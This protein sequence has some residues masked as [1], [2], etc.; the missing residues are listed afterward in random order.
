M[1]RSCIECGNSFER[2][3]P[4][5]ICCSSKCSNA[6]H[7]RQALERYRR[8]RDQGLSRYEAKRV[9]LTRNDSRQREFACVHCG[10]TAFVLK[11]SAKYCS[12][13]CLGAALAN[14]SPLGNPRVRTDPQKCT[15][16]C[17]IKP[18]SEFSVTKHTML[19]MLRCLEC[20]AKKHSDSGRRH[21][22]RTYY[23]ISLEDWLIIYKDQN[24]L[25]AIC[26]SSLPSI[27]EFDVPCKRT[28]RKWATDHCHKTGKIRGILCRPCNWGLGNFRDSPDIAKRAAA[29]LEHHANNES[30][31]PIA[32]P[33]R[34]A[35]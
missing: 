17:H 18:L 12:R 33:S 1:M 25:C 20:V 30:A 7:G 29:Y 21:H 13:A 35:A 26:D 2:A 3:N 9:S 23:G 15:S 19:P 27:D 24:A 22:L 8:L 32:S 28:Y 5:I 16:C 14:R 4:R 6:R 34:R 11:T 10:T 31:R